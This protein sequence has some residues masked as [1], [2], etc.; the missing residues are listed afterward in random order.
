MM[1]ACANFAD[2]LYDMNGWK[3]DFV[4]LTVGTGIIYGF[5]LGVPF[6]FWLYFKWVD[7]NISLIEILCIYGYSLFIYIP[8]SVTFH[9]IFMCSYCLDSLYR[10]L[11]SCSVGRDIYRMLDLDSFPDCQYV[12][13]PKVEGGA[14]D[15]I[16]GGDGALACRNWNNVYA[17]LFP[18]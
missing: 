16:D 11:Q 14:R 8:V 1:A 4:K 15:S 5:A 17:V 18:V 12:E 7:F 9:L 13:P 10:A 6:C 3:Y 2:Y